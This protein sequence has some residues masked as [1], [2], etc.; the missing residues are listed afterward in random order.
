[1][2]K[3]GNLQ[4]NRLSK[5]LLIDHL[6]TTFSKAHVAGSWCIMQLVYLTDV[7]NNKLFTKTLIFAKRLCFFIQLEN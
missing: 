7:L 1:M 6:N 3:Y 2:H 4:T 5:I